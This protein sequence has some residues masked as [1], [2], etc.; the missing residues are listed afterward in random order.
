VFLGTDAA[1]GPWPGTRYWPGFQDMA[2][3]LEVMVR[4]AGFTPLEA[5]A[6]ATSEAARALGL[7][8]EIGTLEPGKRADL[9]LAAGDPAR[10]I[11]ALRRVTMVFCDGRLAARHGHIVLPGGSA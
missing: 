1:F 8:G 7:D 11:R 9:I 3:A 10:D 5:I 4:R 6:M 2:R